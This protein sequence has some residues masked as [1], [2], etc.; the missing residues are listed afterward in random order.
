MLTHRQRERQ[1]LIRRIEAK[2]ESRLLVYVAKINYPIDYNDIHIVGSM[3]ESVGETENIDLLIQSGGGAGTV[4]EKV[5][6]MIR[7]YCKKRFRVFVPN[8][9]KSAATM[10]ALGADTIIMGV[11]SESDPLMLRCQSSKVVSNS[12]YRHNHLLMPERDSSN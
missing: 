4:A 8:L 6:G 3:L 1:E 2:L 5:V 12:G 10:V 7:H 11:T 9:A